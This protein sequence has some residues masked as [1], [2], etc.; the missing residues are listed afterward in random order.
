MLELARE[1]L[2]EWTPAMV[3]PHDPAERC[4]RCDASIG[5]RGTAYSRAASAFARRRVRIFG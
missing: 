4:Y 2:A 3:R 1:T 5:D